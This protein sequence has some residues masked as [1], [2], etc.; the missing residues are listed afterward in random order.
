MLKVGEVTEKAD[1]YS[2]GVV[3]LEL[4]SGRKTVDINRTKGQQCLTKWVTRVYKEKEHTEVEFIIIIL[5]PFDL[6]LNLS[7]YIDDGVGK[8]ITTQIT[9]AS[10]TNKTFYTDSNRKNFIKRVRVFRTDW[11]LQM[12]EPVAG[13]YYPEGIEIP[14]QSHGRQLKR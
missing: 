10:K 6:I 9:S 13:N 11:E 5:F 4:V 3:L 12:N 7:L 8:E 1:V 2:F 14:L